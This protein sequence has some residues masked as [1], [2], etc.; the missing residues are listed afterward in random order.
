MPENTR[1]I[2]VIEFCYYICKDLSIRSLVECTIHELIH[3]ELF[4]N[5]HKVFGC[6]LDCTNTNCP[7]LTCQSYHHGEVFNDEMMRLNAFL[8]NDGLVVTKYAPSA[9]HPV[10]FI[11]TDVK[12]D[13]VL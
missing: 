10:S 12:G 13:L 5:V 7:N 3:A 8:K 4:I 11:S 2:A 9:V 6:S 1:N